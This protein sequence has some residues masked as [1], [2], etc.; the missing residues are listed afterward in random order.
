MTKKSPSEEET[1]ETVRARVADEATMV[2]MPVIVRAARAAA[3]LHA[4]DT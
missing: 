4:Q 2:A 3:S 1:A